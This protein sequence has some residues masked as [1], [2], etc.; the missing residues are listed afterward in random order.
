VRRAIC[1]TAAFHLVEKVPGL[2]ADAEIGRSI[3]IRSLQSIATAGKGPEDIYAESSW[4][5]LI[6]LVLG[7]LQTGSA[8]IMAMR[9]TL[10]SF[11]VGRRREGL[12]KTALVRFL[13]YQSGLYV[14]PTN[15]NTAQ[16]PREI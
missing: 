5:C 13:E 16:K 7:D 1:V 4:A 10:I 3:I 8:D 15:P 2:K 14:S 11:R 9:R 6:L 12:K